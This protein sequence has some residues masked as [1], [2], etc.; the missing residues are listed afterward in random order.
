[1]ETLLEKCKPSVTVAE[2]SGELAKDI[3]V[4]TF[5]DG[6]YIV[7]DRA[8]N[9]H[10]A[11]TLVINANGEKRI[12]E[13]PC[14][15]VITDSDSDTAF[16]LPQGNAINIGNVSVKFNAP[17]VKR[18]NM[19]SAA[20]ARLRLQRTKR[21]ICSSMQELIPRRHRFISTASLLKHRL[22]PTT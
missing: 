22:Q 9:Q 11:R 14:F 2:L 16:K 15:G 20:A 12:V 19:L 1:M 5:Q 21:F 6:S 17:R 3:F 10:K 4:K 8:V 13:L 7:I 18:L